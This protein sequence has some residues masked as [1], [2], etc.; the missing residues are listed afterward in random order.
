MNANVCVYWQILHIL[1][2]EDLVGCI[3]QE[4]GPYAKVHKP[5]S[6]NGISEAPR[7][8]IS[9]EGLAKNCPLLK[10]TFYETNRLCNQPWSVRQAEQDVVLARKNTDDDVS[11]QI[12][13]GEY[14][15][16]PHELHMLD[17]HYFE[18]PLKFMPERFLKTDDDGK[19]VVDIGTIRPFGGGEN[20]ICLVHPVLTTV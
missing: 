19:V 7:L 9:H 13:A 17:E 18:H 1:A 16:V 20:F 10:A 4:I 12:R 14:I 8:S 5:M 2:Q 11:Y 3:R 15:T 6:I